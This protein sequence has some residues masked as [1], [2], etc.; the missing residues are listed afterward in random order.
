MGI[1]NAQTKSAPAKANTVVKQ[2]ASNSVIIM[3]ANITEPF[4]KYPYYSALAIA[5]AIKKHN[6]DTILKILSK[7]AGSNTL[8]D[9]Y[10][11][12]MK[13]AN[14]AFIYEAFLKQDS[15]N[16]GELYRELKYSCNYIFLTNQMF[17]DAIKNY[18]CD[19]VI[20]ILRENIIHGEKN[21][22]VIELKM[23]Y[24]KDKFIQDTFFKKASLIR[25]CLDLASERPRSILTSQNPESSSE[26]NNTVLKSIGSLDATVFADAFAKIVV[27]RFKQDLN[28][29]F[30]EKMKAD[31][32]SS[33]ELK[34]I[35]PHTHQLLQLVDKDIY[36]F[37]TYIDGLRQKLEEDF[38]NIFAGTNALLET[39]QYKDK[40]TKDI[41]VQSIISTMLQVSD[42]LVHK[43]HP[44]MIIEQLNLNG[45]YSSSNEGRNI[46]GGLQLLQ[47]FSRGLV[48]KDTTGH[49]WVKGLDSLNMLFK[50]DS[51]VGKVWLGLLCQ[52]VTQENTGQSL[53][54]NDD[55][56]IQ[57]TIHKM[58][59]EPA[60][61]SDSK[62]FFGALFNQINQIELTVDD[63]RESGKKGAAINWTQTISLYENAV[64]LIKL[65]PTVK[66]ILDPNYVM[67]RYWNRSLFIAETMPRV[68]AEMKGK[69][70]HAAVQH[71]SGLM[72]AF[73]FR[74]QYVKGTIKII[75]F[76]T[77]RNGFTA[78]KI[79]KHIV[80]LDTVFR[81]D[82]AR[83][84]F[85]KTENGT[86]QP[87]RDYSDP[88]GNF[89]K[90]SN[91]TDSILIKKIYVDAH[92]TQELNTG[93]TD[94]FLKYGGFA[95]SLVESRTSDE[96]A[97]LLDATMVPPGGTRLKETG[98]MI[99]VNGYLG[100][101]HHFST[102]D[103][104]GF[105]SVSAPLGFNLSFGIPRKQ[106][107]GLTKSQKFWDFVK[108]HT[109]QIFA[110]IVDVGA[111]AG[112][113]FSNNRSDLPKIT[114]EN[115]F[116]PGLF[117]HF[118]RMFNTPLNL[119]IGYQAQ[120]RLYNIVGQSLTLQPFTFR[121]NVNASWDIPFWMLFYKAN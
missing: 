87:R 117:L 51:T 112:L 21:L 74:E 37:Q 16:N 76:D 13:Y 111:L 113:R 63:I 94:K 120:P 114:L 3:T 75:K 84:F 97:A 64:S 78:P 25:P 119:G 80:N 81:I 17:A 65:V 28:A 18:N 6:R 67:P 100:L 42:G 66:T 24:S 60:Y 36:N 118:G 70:Y 19:T 5:D 12:K 96:V 35:L 26:K 105:S 15:I 40:F 32:D 14:N 109:V 53:K 52:N 58:Y 85:Y 27:R 47:I 99:G 4:E 59:Y 45:D 56:D 7:C 22:S 34:I 9:P 106:V 89:I 11:L 23:L 1:S 30:F 48:S 115:I 103:S 108:P 121:F 62:N 39:K 88:V 8:I 20:K 55:M 107:I 98:V 73:D 102:G 79:E 72:K 10:F 71:I 110:G 2:P 44:G 83:C 68:Y 91:C 69:Q 101:Q 46:K 54:F 116:S 93:I 43:T 104:S 90:L 49:Y 50:G 41:V 82:T 92:A 33:I 29:L 77:I 38:S 95:A 61:Y 31:M 86:L 57:E